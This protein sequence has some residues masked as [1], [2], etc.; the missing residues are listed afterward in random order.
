MCNKK[1]CILCKAIHDGMNCKQYQDDLKRRAVND[2]AAKATQAML[3]V[4]EGREREGRGRMQPRCIQM[5][6]VGKG[7]RGSEGEEDATM[8]VLWRYASG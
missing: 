5:L 7:G 4:C 8:A 6:E 1:N 2:E 3:E